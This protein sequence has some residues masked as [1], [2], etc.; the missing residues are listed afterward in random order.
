M[1]P[2]EQNWVGH[3]YRPSGNS[4][5]VYILGIRQIETIGQST[6]WIVLGKNARRGNKF[7]TQP[8]GTFK[9]ELDARAFHKTECRRLLK[10]GYLDITSPEYKLNMQSFPSALLTLSS[11]GIIEALEGAA[12]KVIAPF[13]EQDPIGPPPPM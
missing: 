11:P 5:K 10:K 9:S 1:T 6:E 2:Q 7:I 12:A 4:D 3:C 8:K 13:K